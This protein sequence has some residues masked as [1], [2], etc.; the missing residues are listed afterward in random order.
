MFPLPKYLVQ[1]CFFS[2]YVSTIHA[3]HGFFDRLAD[4]AATL[5]RQKVRYDLGYFSIDYPMGDVP[6]DRG[7]CTDVIIRAYRKL[8]I[9]LQ[10]LVYE[11]MRRHF[12]QY[13]K[14]WGLRS[15]D[16]NIDHR[17]VPNLMIFFHRMGAAIP[18][19]KLADD[20]R[21]GDMVCWS[22][23]RGMK[24]I[25]MVVSQKSLDHKRYLIIHNIGT[26][27][28]IEDVLFA[29]PIIGHYRFKSDK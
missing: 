25:G 6:R 29:Y 12:G 24:H 7:V 15:T 21:P 8:N 17:R 28:V 23:E 19:S 9:D 3:Q 4:S 11:D 16:T 1:L 22:L 10:Q 2:F 18:V 27:Q 20:Y 13:P 14:N 5:S 26:G